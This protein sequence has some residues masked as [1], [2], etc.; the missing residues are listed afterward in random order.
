[1]LLREAARRR[2]EGRGSAVSGEGDRGYV[3]QGGGRQGGG[4]CGEMTARTVR[5]NGLSMLPGL[6]PGSR[7]L[8]SGLS[9][10]RLRRGSLVLV[11]APGG[12]RRPLLK[13]LIGLPGERIELRGA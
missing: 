13:R 12:S 2:R 10:A 5:V 4:S 3:R 7:L 1:M 9:A 11:R 6:A 8:V